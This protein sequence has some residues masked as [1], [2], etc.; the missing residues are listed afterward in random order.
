MEMYKVTHL[1]EIEDFSTCERCPSLPGSAGVFGQDFIHH[2]DGEVQGD[3][4]GGSAAH[5]VGDVT[6]AEEEGMGLIGPAADCV[7]C[8]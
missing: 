7:Y 4:G 5:E 8:S 2:F 1:T 3:L 6:H